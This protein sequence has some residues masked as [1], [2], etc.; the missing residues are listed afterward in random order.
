MKEQYKPSQEEI[1]KA[2]S[3]MTPELKKLNE[4]R[5]RKFEEA[6][7]EFKSILESEK[8]TRETMKNMGEEIWKRSK[9]EFSGID[10]EALEKLIEFMEKV[11]EEK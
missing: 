3:M 11:I 7:P 6:L 4:E 8:L 1:N 5:V 2:E 9:R 10:I